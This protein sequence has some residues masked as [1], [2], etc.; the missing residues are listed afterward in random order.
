MPFCVVC[1]KIWCRMDSAVE[2]CEFPIARV[3]KINFPS[4]YTCGKICATLLAKEVTSV[5]DL[6]EIFIVKRDKKQG[7]SQEITVEQLR[8]EPI[9]PD[10]FDYCVTAYHG[11][12]RDFM[13]DIVL[14]KLQ[15]DTFSDIEECWGEFNVNGQTIINLFFMNGECFRFKESLEVKYEEFSRRFQ[16]F[17]QS[18]GYSG[19]KYF[20][21]DGSEEHQHS[22]WFIQNLSTFQHTE[23][24]PQNLYRSLKDN[25]FWVNSQKTYGVVWSFTT[26]T[27]SNAVDYY[28]CKIEKWKAMIEKFL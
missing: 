15:T 11:I 12:D 25:T 2:S 3:N 5:N 24:D 1:R 27:A 23:S 13:S 16:I 7:F 18:K 21:A 8:N 14:D 10:Q 17:V 28:K 22:G 6:P 26:K 9:S 4:L 19:K 20:I